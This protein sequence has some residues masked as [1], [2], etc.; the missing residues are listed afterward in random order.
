MGTGWVPKSTGWSPGRLIHPFGCE[1]RTQLLQ[2][3]NPGAHSIR[4]TNTE[5]DHRT[6]PTGLVALGVARAAPVQA[7]SP[8]SRG[9]VGGR[10]APRC[11]AAAERTRTGSLRPYFRK[12]CS[13]QEVISG[14]L[15]AQADLGAWPSQWEWELWSRIERRLAPH[16]KDPR[17]PTLQRIAAAFGDYQNAVVAA[18]RAYR[19]QRIRE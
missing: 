3:R 1:L 18:Q 4:A 5:G 17:L 15:R 7:R 8:A 14:L 2:F 16:D 13:Q 6:S 10:Q 19:Q 12:A 11:R 9:G